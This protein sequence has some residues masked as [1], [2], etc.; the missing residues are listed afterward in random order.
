MIA[1]LLSLCIVA[2]IGPFLAVVGISLG[3]ALSQ[4]ID[5]WLSHKFHR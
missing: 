3:C 5:E 4:M 2:L 1:K